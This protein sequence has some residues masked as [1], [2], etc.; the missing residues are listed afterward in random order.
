VLTT[1]TSAEQLDRYG[2]NDLK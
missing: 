1:L 2:G